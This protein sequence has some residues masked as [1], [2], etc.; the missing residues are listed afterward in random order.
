MKDFYVIAAILACGAA[1]IVLWTYDSSATVAPE[2]AGEWRSSRTAEPL[3]PIPQHVPL[4][5]DRVALG[6][7]LF[8]EPRLS[9]DGTV[10]CSSCHA[11]D[12]GGVDRLP[13]S[14]GVRGGVGE[15]NAPT[16]LNSGFSFRQFWDGRAATLEEQVD[17]PTHNPLEMASSWPEIIQK[18]ATSADYASE[19]AR[20][21]GDGITPDNVRDAIATYERSLYTPNSRFDR[22]LR[23]EVE[24]LDA[25]ERQGFALF[26]SFG[27]VACHQG[28]GVGGN[29]F[30]R[31]G[32]MGDYFA[33][34]GDVTEAD[35][36]RYNVTGREED[37]FVFKVP[38]L[39]NVE[40]TSPYF[41]DGSAPSL[42][43]AVAVMARYQ[44]G[45]TLASD[46]LVALVRFLKT[47]T[48]EQPRP[49]V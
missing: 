8:H 11:L 7:R 13:R 21:Y 49:P 34:R 30:Q 23:G 35:Y 47:L 27:C 38:S 3:A 41:H 45:R 5:A 48:G 40:L 12:R 28:V 29:M 15:V 31:F 19:F 26:K 14:V 9:G 18:L 17:G 46:E 44:L 25:E 43:A 24:A 4:D 33:D 20:I 16:V 2:R 32:V 1:G 36:G 42:E 39:R 10:A 22:Y 37:R 6:E